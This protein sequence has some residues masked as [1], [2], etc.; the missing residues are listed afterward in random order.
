LLVGDFLPSILACPDDDV[1][2]ILRQCARNPEPRVQ[3]IALNGFSYYSDDVIRKELIEL[4]RSSGPT[5]LL[6]YVLSWQRDLLQPDAAKIVAILTGYL[7]SDSAVQ[8]GGALHGL[9]FVEAGYVWDQQ[10]DMPDRIETEVFKNIAHIHQFHQREALRPLCLFLG[11][12]KTQ[13]D[14]AREVLWDLTKI[15]SVHE[16]ALICIG[17]RKDARD[18]PELGKAILGDDPSASSVPYQMCNCYGTAAIPYLVKALQEGASE[19]V[20][21]A[22]SKELALA[23]RPE[24]FAYWAKCIRA[25]GRYRERAL[26]DVRDHFRDENRTTEEQVLK[27]LD[28]KA[29][30]VPAK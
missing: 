10:P 18:L 24:G 9:S 11:A 17:W 12:A 8:V 30:A 16:Q 4:L 27:F 20:R 22:C 21:Y 2:A 23:G 1:L 14:R 19:G 3:R 15:P 29:G 5:D 13:G 25:G 6:A 7:N 28:V 26:Q